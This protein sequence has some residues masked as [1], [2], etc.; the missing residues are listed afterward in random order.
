MV[1][2]DPDPDEEVTGVDDGSVTL[3]CVGF[4]DEPGPE[5]P[6]E[7]AAIGV[8]PVDPD[9]D[10]AVTELDNGSVTMIDCAALDDLLV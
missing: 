9:P 8:V 7:L 10:V 5:A 2:I 3:D 1:P 6:L 4:D